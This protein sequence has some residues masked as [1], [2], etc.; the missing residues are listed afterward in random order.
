MKLHE[1]TLPSYDDYSE[2]AQNLRER[3]ERASDTV[4][5][6]TIKFEA[7][8]LARKCPY[9]DI[10]RFCFQIISQ[11]DI[12]LRLIDNDEDQS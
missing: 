3:A 4:E 1:R 12:A 7:D 2:Q 5:W 9:F 11:V 10:A 6:Q 8:Q